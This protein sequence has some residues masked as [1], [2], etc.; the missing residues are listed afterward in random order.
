[1]KKLMTICLAVLVIAA[2]VRA[3]ALSISTARLNWESLNITGDITWIED[4]KYSESYAYASNETGYDEDYEGEE[5]WVPT[6]AYASTE[7]SNGRAYTDPYNLY[8][9]MYA[10]ASK[11]TTT[12]AYAYADA[13]RYGN[14]TA[15]SAGLVEFSTSYSLQQELSTDEVGESA[16]GYAEAGLYIYNND[17]YGYDQNTASLSNSLSEPGYIYLPDSG[18]LTVSVWFDDGQ[19]GYFEGWVYNGGNAQIPEPATLSLLGLGALSL[20]RRKK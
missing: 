10:S 7:T 12:W 9:E 8:E 2:V 20:L 15:D 3:D 18:T 13:Y 17:T 5:G 1:M 16:Y 4:S 6:Y 14:F 19:S 11:S